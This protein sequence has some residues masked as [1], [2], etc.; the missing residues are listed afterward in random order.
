MAHRRTA[1]QLV[2]A[3]SAICSRCIGISGIACVSGTD[4][5]D[6]VVL[7]MTTDDDD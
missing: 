5:V 6:F 2:C 7:L 4:L 3:V 1:A